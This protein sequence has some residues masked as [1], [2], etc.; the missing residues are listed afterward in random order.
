M[1]QQQTGGKKRRRFP[2]V[3]GSIIGVLLAAVLLVVLAWAVYAA[4]GMRAASQTSGTLQTPGLIADV[5]IVRDARD[6]PHIIASND[7]DL[8]F[9]QGYAEASDRLFQMDLLRR[10][11][12]GRLAEVLG[13]AVLA[14]DENARIA[15][16]ARIVREQWAELDP[17][18]RMLVQAFAD[19]VNAA[20]QREPLPPEFHI[21]LY[22][23]EPWRAQDSL[24]VGMATV[25]DLIDPWGDVIRR[26]AVAHASGAAPLD[27]LYAVT[28][29]AYDAP[30]DGARIAKLPP[31][32]A[33]DTN[34]S[35]AVV[36]P[37]IAERP[38]TGSNE[39]A[40]G[41][42][43]STTGRA[44]LANDPH[45][46]LGIPGIWYLVDLRSND[47]HVAGGSLAGTPGVIL[48]H[49]ENVAWGATNGTVVTEVVY[50]DALK[51]A[52]TRR[53]IFHVRFAKDRTF[54][55]Y[56]T[57]H[58]FAAATANGIAYA[59]DWN[60]ARKPLT[61]LEAFRGLD[62]A[63]S[64]ADAIKAL[65][66]YPGPP[67][68]FVIADRSGAV[69]YQLAGLIPKDPLWGL[70]VHASS[71][72]KYPFV[73]FE[74]LPHVA[75]SRSGL[76]FTANNRT[77]G[78][79]YPLRLTPNFAPPYRAHR[80]EHLL[81][82]KPRLSVA[83][84]ASMQTDTL[85]LPERD[86]AR[87]VV[88]AVRRKG[89]ERDRKIAPYVKA[90]AEWNGRF[91][92]DSRGAAI[93]WEVRRIA[94]ASLAQ[95]NAGDAAAAYQASANGADLVL[96]MRVLRERPRGWWPHSD[97][98]ALLADSLDTAVAHY[99]T[100]LLQTWGQYGKATVRHPLAMMGLS[101]L[102]GA[103][104]PGDGDSYGIHVQTATHSQSFRAV[105][106]VGNWDAGGMV[107][108]SGES[109]EPAS[110]HYTDLSGTWIRQQL[111]PLPFSD[112]AVRAAA[113]ATLTL[114][115]ATQR[116]PQ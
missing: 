37:R 96:L 83:D 61:P 53:E 4:I 77:Y 81:S 104:F 27:E 56:D 90:L 46:R 82:A 102:N 86:L 43:H 70:H 95:Q 40:V 14:A 63:R 20:M 13:P 47:L 38:A 52:K 48:G 88:A 109:G 45:L 28:D 76:V 16:I 101:F 11:V 2:G 36:L 5:R 67:Q 8:L 12:Y 57:P 32:K 50:R 85:S 23:P 105:W 34:K 84:L 72:P 75:A 69:A 3:V 100:A 41:A 44:L 66:A 103:T 94:V 58:G 87:A 71:D 64:I 24:A 19:G 116:S 99:G 31:L 106:D 18:E 35:A 9:A 49:N 54:T 89:R 68:N 29:P 111:V 115:P 26:D 74:E 91:D 93:A 113:R 114:T 10:Y 112:A 79:G 80:V 1:D 17:H 65:R 30:V 39:W 78:A 15:P 73:A 108:P 33:R 92:P 42:G 110:G 60:A 25:L 98:D 51:N 97:Y 21:L 7:H 6:I 22:K 55:Y 107:I 59:V 62:N